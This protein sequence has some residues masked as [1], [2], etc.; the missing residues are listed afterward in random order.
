[1]KVNYLLLVIIVAIG[2]AQAQDFSTTEPQTPIIQLDGP[3][4]GV[5]YLQGQLARDLEETFGAQPYVTQ[6]GW[7]VENRFFTLTNGNSG[8][9]EFVALLGGMEQGLFLPSATMLVGM[10]NYKGMEFG[11]GPNVSLTG[12]AI[13]FA[14]GITVQSSGINFPINVAY[15]PGPG[16]GRVS[17]L[18]GFNAIS[19][20]ARAPGRSGFWY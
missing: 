12:S 5:T 7:Q 9:V 15:V 18:V 8:I 4:F 17:L 20:P 13:A 16:G 2:S 11:F 1:M 10:R 14:A 3:R 19:R 6:F